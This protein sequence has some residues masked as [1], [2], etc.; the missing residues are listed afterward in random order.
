MT[1]LTIILAICGILIAIGLLG[2]I[3]SL[4]GAGIIII[5][6]LLPIMILVYIVARLFKKFKNKFSK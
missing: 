5:L 2:F 3:L 6:K 1:I 4:L